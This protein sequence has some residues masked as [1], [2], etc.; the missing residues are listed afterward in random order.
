[1]N[2]PAAEVLIIGYG[3]PGRMDDGLGP[4]FADEAALLNL[5]GVTVESNY[6]LTVEDAHAVARHPVVIFADATGEEN[7]EPFSFKRIEPARN[8]GPSFTSH[9]VTP[10]EVL[11]L[12]I[13]L[14]GA[15]TRAYV[16]GIRGYQFE[17]FSERLSDG[18]RQN[19]HAAVAFL[20]KTINDRT[21]FS[22]EPALPDQPP[23]HEKR[24]HPCR[25]KRP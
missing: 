23:I 16:L 1:M 10:E 25:R 8:S 9:S 7:V 18:A 17:S 19:L 24:S 15:R 20:K 2:K 14:F 4:A 11:A 12:S 6:Q 21:L 22:A 3:N 5:H 13:T